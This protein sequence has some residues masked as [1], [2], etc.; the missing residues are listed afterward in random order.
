MTASR[1]AVYG[2]VAAVVSP[3][4]LEGPRL[5]RLL[6]APSRE[7]R[8]PSTAQ[9]HS[10]EHD[11]LMIALRWAHRT[12]GV[13]SRL[14]GA[15]WKNTCLYRSAAGCLALRW[16]GCG[17]EA[18]LRIGARRDP[19]GDEVQAHA[20][21]AGFPEQSGHLPG[22]RPLGEVRQGESCTD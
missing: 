18:T 22:Y 14:P 6:A 12:T 17:A 9:S 16:L 15:R 1:S 11:R 8:Q 7:S 10:G 21:I 2:V 19:A 3:W 20:W 4:H 13:L 5:K